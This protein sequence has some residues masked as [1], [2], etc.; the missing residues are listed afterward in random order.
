MTPNSKIFGGHTSVTVSVTLSQPA[1][2]K[3]TKRPKTIVQA[4]NRLSSP[5]APP[6]RF[7]PTRATRLAQVGVES[8]F[9]GSTRHENE[10]WAPVKMSSLMNTCGMR[11][12]PVRNPSAETADVAVW[13]ATKVEPAQ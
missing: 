3:A 9:L 4:A 10:D 2:P 13:T 8:A 6:R 12:S 1:D 5:G 7:L 11:Y